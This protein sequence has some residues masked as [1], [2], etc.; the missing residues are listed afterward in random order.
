METP[1]DQLMD[2]ILNKDKNKILKL[3]QDG[4][5]INTRNIGDGRSVVTEAV[6]MLQDDP[7]R[8]E[9]IGFLLEHGADPKLLDEERCGPLRPAML[10]MD[11]EMLRLLMDH[12][13][14]PNLESGFTQDESLYDWAEFDYCYNVYCINPPDE[15]SEEDKRDEDTW[16]QFLKMQAEKYS[17]RPPDHLFLLRERGAKTAAELRSLSGNNKE[18]NMGANEE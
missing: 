5:D 2:A 12:G 13:A 16:L 3:L 18:K 8:Y 11:T 6:F 14:D 1:L 9:M 4:V 10:G 15:P 17:V 7:E